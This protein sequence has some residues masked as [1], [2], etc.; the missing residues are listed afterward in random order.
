[1]TLD[2]EPVKYSKNDG[3]L[4]LHNRG[5]F[6]PGREEFCR[7][8]AEAT[9]RQDKVRAVQISLASGT[10]RI[11]FDPGRVDARTMANRFSEAVQSAIAPKADNRRT[12]GGSEGWITLLMFT[13]GEGRS[14][15]EILK[16]HSGVTRLRNRLL[17]MDSSL[18]KRVAA[19]ISG[20]S[21]V[22][23]SRKTFWT[24]DL[25]IRFDPGRLSALAI[26]E[27][28]ERVLRQAFQPALEAAATSAEGEPGVVRGFR[29]IWYLTLAGG[30]FG[31]TLVGLL[32]PGVPT[33]PFLLAT[34]YYL[35]RSSPG[36]NRMLRRSRFFG[37]ILEDL[38]TYGGLRP[39]SRFK[40]VG[41][42]LTL[43]LVILVL[44]GPP[45]LV[46]ALTIGTMTASLY[47]IMQIPGVPGP[48]Y[49]S[50]LA[51]DALAGATV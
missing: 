15:W 32:V 37:P 14:A 11:D 12:D 29:R 39:L 6:R 44:I 26:V 49:G 7:R 50:G 24:N 21:G 20:L 9:A 35:A 38:Q 31:M 45:F 43:G 40:L 2:A 33:V 3:V 13:W 36:L 27:V 42:T 16:D 51:P 34:S 25:D 1:M 41:L 10:C 4:L 48:K 17:Q 22:I 47:F 46:L 23:S 5:L 8:L 19:A 28:A 18:A 30:S